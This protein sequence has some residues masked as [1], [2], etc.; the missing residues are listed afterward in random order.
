MSQLL[1]IKNMLRSALPNEQLR[2]Q[3]KEYSEGK[4]EFKFLVKEPDY[5]SERLAGCVVLKTRWAFLIWSVLYK[6]D[7]S[8]HIKLEGRVEGGTK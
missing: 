3:I 5:P 1:K 6:I 7:P 8:Q 4:W 2:I